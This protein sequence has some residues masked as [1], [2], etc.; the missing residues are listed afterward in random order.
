MGSSPSL[1][2]HKYVPAPILRR[3]QKKGCPKWDSPLHADKS[4]LFRGE[5]QQSN[6]TRALD[7]LGQLTLMLCASTGHAAGQDLA[8]LGHVTLQLCYVLRRC[9]PFCG[10][11]RRADGPGGE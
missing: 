9:K 3:R 7:R 8:A 6:V 2:P 1:E 11:G 10:D 5:R 4:L